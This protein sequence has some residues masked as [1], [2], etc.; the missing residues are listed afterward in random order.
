MVETIGLDVGGTKIAGGV[1]DH[2][3]V[4]KASARRRSSMWPA[5]SRRPPRSP[6]PALGWPAREWSIRAAPRSSSPRTSPGATNRYGSASRLPSSCQSSSKMTPMRRPGVSTGSAQEPES[7][8][9]SSLPTAPGL[10]AVASVMAA[11]CGGHSALR[12]R[13]GISRWCRAGIGV[14]A[15][16]GAVGRRMQVARPWCA[17]PANLSRPVHRGPRHCVSC[18]AGSWR[19][20]PASTSRRRRSPVTRPPANS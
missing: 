9:C 19:N 10:A 3:G 13:S 7:G 8:T 12:V 14:A 20:S 4:V 17:R 2:L 18:A 5:N 15:G 1:V 6:W 11:C 16:T